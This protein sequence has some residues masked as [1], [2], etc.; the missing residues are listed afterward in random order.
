M[1]ITN[2][3]PTVVFLMSLSAQMPMTVDGTVNF[4]IA[5]KL[6]DLEFKLK[7]HRFF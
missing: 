2:L 7:P 1:F 4:N 3:L 6:F 5:K